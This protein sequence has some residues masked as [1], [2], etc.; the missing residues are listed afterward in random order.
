MAAEECCLHFEDDNFLA[1]RLLPFT[2]TTWRTAVSKAEL[3][4]SVY[5]RVECNIASNV[6][7]TGL[8]VPFKTLFYHQHCYTK[9][10]LQA[11]ITSA[12]KNKQTDHPTSSEVADLGPLLRST[13]KISSAPRKKKSLFPDICVICQKERKW[14]FER[15]H[16]VRDTLNTVRFYARR[17][18]L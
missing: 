18:I 16:R 6:L 12:L 14:V 11:R 5:G 4:K 1:K 3:W 7:T 2:E 15:G 10:T 8:S 13:S 9:F 17:P